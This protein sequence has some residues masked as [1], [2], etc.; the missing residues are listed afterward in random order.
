VT[1]SN[2]NLERQLS[3]LDAF[4]APARGKSVARGMDVLEHNQARLAEPK[5]HR[6]NGVLTLLTGTEMGE[7]ETSFRKAIQIA[8]RQSAKWFELRAATS[9]ARLLMKQARRDEVRAMLTGTYNWLA[10]ALRPPT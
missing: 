4:A 7:S 8:R 6:L 2:A 5:L 1:R 10:R 9:L 3:A